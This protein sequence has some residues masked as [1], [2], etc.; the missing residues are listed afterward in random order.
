MTPD[1]REKFLEDMKKDADKRPERFRKVF[2][3]RYDKYATS[4]EYLKETQSTQKYID[5][6]ARYVNKA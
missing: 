3:S 6:I 2:P 4:M 1:A 5:D